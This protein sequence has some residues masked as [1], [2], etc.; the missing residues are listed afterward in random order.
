M[1][2][3]NQH[4]LLAAMA[5]LT[6]GVARAQAPTNQLSHTPVAPTAPSAPQGPNNNTIGPGGTGYSANRNDYVQD[7]YVEQASS[8]NY[9][10][11]TQTDSRTGTARDNGAGSSASIVQ[12]GTN[13]DAFQTQI[14]D[15]T[16]NVSGFRN[17][18][19]AIQRGDRSKSTQTQTGGV[20]N[21]ARVLQDV[22]SSNNQ[23]TQT[24]TAGRNNSA[25]IGQSRN[26]TD[27]NVNNT[28]TQT[29]TG[30]D[31]SLAIQQ[32]SQNS[33]AT[34]TQGGSFNSGGI[35]Q[36]AR[37]SNN[38]AV[39]NQN[40][41][42]NKA[43]ITQSVGNPQENFDFNFARQTQDASATSNS[44]DINQRA[45]HSY[46]EQ[47]QTGTDN[48]SLITQGALGSDSNVRSAA[49]TTQS[50]TSNSVTITQR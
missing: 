27:P 13:N 5:L 25:S 44:A 50:G 11:V 21:T 6:A 43:R 7:S 33:V 17:E 37:G 8:S 28:A 31:N 4:I 48:R 36:G 3:L 34:Q 16:S 22:G 42:S 38:T 12:T 9:A 1:K 45:N 15:N 46:A 32:Q 39:Q 41:T 49:Y 18:V 35:Y 30:N 20:Y 29:Q 26:G 24:Q 47:I 10:N 19:G 40:G 2:K 14:L 23:A